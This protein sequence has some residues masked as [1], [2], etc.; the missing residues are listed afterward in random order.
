MTTE[1]EKL[2]FEKKDE[3]KEKE[4]KKHPLQCSWTLWYDYPGRKNQASTYD[5]YLTKVYTVSTVEDFWSVVNYIMS[6]T[7]LPHGANYRLFKD[8]IEPKWEDKQNQKGGA[9]TATLSK[10]ESGQ[11]LDE[12]WLNLMLA[13]IGDSL[14]DGDLIC[15][16]NVSIRKKEDRLAV[17]TKTS[18]PKDDICKIGEAIKSNCELT[19]KIDF[20]T[21]EDMLKVMEMNGR[22]R[23]KYYI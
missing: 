11:R 4:T 15:G 19:A 8:G 7:S 10:K 1:P 5:Q 23:A 20:K 18:D 9:W 21:H 2:V 16:I 3:K 6:P 17:W 12:M 13:A 22:P 14:G